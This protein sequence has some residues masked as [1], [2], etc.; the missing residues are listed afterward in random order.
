MTTQV[1]TAEQ[2]S[3]EAYH[4]ET[5]HVSGSSLATILNKCPAKWRYAEPKDAKHFQFGTTAHTNVLEKSRFDAEYFR[6]PS[7]SEFKDL[8][9]SVAGVTSW[10]KDKGVAGYSGKKMPELLEMVAKT[11]EKPFI[12]HEILEQVKKDAGNRTIVPADD[13]DKVMRMRQ[14]LINNPVINDIIE[15]GH[16]EISIYSEI[17][18]VPVKVRLDYVSKDACIIDYKTTQSAQPEEF[19]RLASNLGYYMKMALQHDVFQIAYGRPPTA[20]KLLAQEKEPPFLGK[21]FTLTPWQL[22]LGR[23]QYQAA[24]SLYARCKETDIWPG[25]GLTNAEMDL[26]TPDW[27]LAKNKH[28]KVGE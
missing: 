11:G 16:P 24:L 2:L 21:L 28:I 19:G 20:V 23:E 6:E 17:N 14:T 25:Y 15:R 8:I 4:A 1:F 27:V 18:G 26:P 5:E 9:T 7:P 13:Y 3:N 12:W 10:L 22:A